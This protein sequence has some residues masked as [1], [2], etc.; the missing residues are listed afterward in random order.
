LGKV[1]GLAVITS[2]PIDL[3]CLDCRYRCP[4][5]GYVLRDQ[6]ASSAIPRRLS[7][8]LSFPLLLTIFQMCLAFFFSGFGIALQNAQ[9]NGLVGLMRDRQSI[10]LSVLHATYGMIGIIVPNIIFDLSRTTGIGAFLAP[11]SSTYFSTTK[12]WNFQ[13]IISTGLALVNLL[14]L[15][16]VFKGRRLRGTHISLLTTISVKFYCFF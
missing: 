11:L 5:H 2:S 12:H 8:P 9:A 15:A 14:M 6:F 10:K 16:F 3:G 4:V 7:F 1:C 13:F